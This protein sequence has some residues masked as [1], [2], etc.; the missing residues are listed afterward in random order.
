MAAGLGAVFGTAAAV[1]T[2]FFAQRKPELNKKAAAGQVEEKPVVAATRAQ[3][4]GRCPTPSANVKSD[5]P[6]GQVKKEDKK[7]IGDE[8]V[9]VAKVATNLVQ[10]SEAIA[11][12]EIMSIAES[13]IPHDEAVVPIQPEVHF[14]AVTAIEDQ[15]ENQIVEAVKE[16]EKS[17]QVEEEEEEEEEEEVEELCYPVKP[18]TFSEQV[19]AAR[20]IIDASPVASPVQPEQTPERELVKEEDAAPV[21]TEEIPVKEDVV[22][23]STAVSAEIAAPV[24]EEE[25]PVPVA[26]AETIVSPSPVVEASVEVAEVAAPFNQ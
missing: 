9:S 24:K 8:T 21:K 18:A 11:E 14:E 16:L 19:L 3:S 20:E 17:V 1:L 5:Q 6:V 7:P 15:I 26:K 22:K 4:I 23:S 2:T 13:K 10:H 25:I 12:A